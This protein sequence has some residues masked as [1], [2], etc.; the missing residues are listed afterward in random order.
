LAAAEMYFKEVEVAKGAI[1]ALELGLTATQFYRDSTEAKDSFQMAVLVANQVN[2]FPS[3][4]QGFAQ[5]EGT[6][7]GANPSQDSVGLCCFG[8]KSLGIIGVDDS[9][10]N[11]DL[12]VP[13]GVAG[14]SYANLTL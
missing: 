11:Y 3:P 8:A 4:T 5:I 6:D 12:V 2:V 7:Q 1:Q 9:G 10:G 13:L 14:T